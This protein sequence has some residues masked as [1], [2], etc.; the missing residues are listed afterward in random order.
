MCYSSHVS[1]TVSSQKFNHLYILY[2][3]LSFS[4][5]AYHENP[6]CNIGLNF[7]FTDFQSLWNWFKRLFQLK[8]TSCYI[9]NCL[10]SEYQLDSTST[11][12]PPL[13]PLCPS[14]APARHRRRSLT[15]QWS[16][17]GLVDTALD[18]GVRQKVWLRTGPTPSK[19]V[20]FK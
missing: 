15:A 10:D 8:Y 11:S 14:A 18:T 2:I 4:V 12:T 13:A 1:Y 17:R 19:A 9:P 6:T 5:Q 3:H 16:P 20:L 7:D